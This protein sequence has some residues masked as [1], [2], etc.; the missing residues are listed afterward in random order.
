MEKID[1]AIAIEPLMRNLCECGD[2]GRMIQYDNYCFLA[3]ID[4]LGHGSEARMVALS[5]EE[6]LELHY[7]EEL[8]DI[9]QGL[10][11]HLIGSRGAVVAL[12]KI[13]LNTGDLMHTAIGN[14]TTRIFGYQSARLLSRDGI[15]GYGVINPVVQKFILKHGDTLLLH[16]DGISEHFDEL[17]CIGLFKQDA[18]VISERIMRKFSKNNDDASCIVLKY[19]K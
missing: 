9:M 17:E 18:K 11:E 6:Y 8:I 7:G 5:T 4:V 14:I 16:S 1:Y 19:L 3:L 2:T 12:C 13:N 15:V 10:H